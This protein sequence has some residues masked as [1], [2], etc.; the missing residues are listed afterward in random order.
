[1]TGSTKDGAVALNDSERA[2]KK[3]KGDWTI[4]KEKFIELIDAYKSRTFIEDLDMLEAMGGT[5]AVLKALKTD[6][7]NGIEILSKP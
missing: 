7:D 3:D 6:S 5:D 2:E 1:M 4:E